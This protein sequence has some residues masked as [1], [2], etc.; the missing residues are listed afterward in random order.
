M[1]IALLVTRL[2][3]Q[4]AAK[5][6]LTAGVVYFLVF[7][8]CRIRYWRDPHSAFFSIDNVF[9]WKYSLLREHEARHFT[10]IY[11]APSDE[12]L[13]SAR[14]GDSPWMCAA[15]ATVKRDKDDYFEAS[16]GSLL[17]GLDP[18]ERKAL[19]LSIFFANTDPSLHPS[20]Q[21]KWVDRVADSVSTYN[22]TEDEFRHLQDLEQTSN[23][24]EKGV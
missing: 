12:G 20:W 10:G 18:R 6:L 8:F 15:L 24:Y 9:E 16:V 13:E 11:N 4:P 23:F 19:H 5:L 17:G 3:K 22:V 2:L 21:Q 1:K 14:G 7:Q